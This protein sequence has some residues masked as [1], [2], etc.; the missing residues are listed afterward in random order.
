MIQFK[1]FPKMP[2]LSREVIVTEKIDGTNASIFIQNEVL[3]EGA[4]PVIVAR[5]G[6]FT[7]RVGSRTRW[8]TPSDDN[9]GF[10]NWVL[11]NSENLFGLG[12]G[13]H[14]GEWWGSGIQSGYGLQ[15]GEKRFSLFNT[16]RWSESRPSCTH[17][18]PVL[19]R[20]IFDTQRIQLVL[21]ELAKNG[22]WAAPGFMKPEG[23]VIY[24]VAG[25]IGF[26]KTIHKD[27]LPKSLAK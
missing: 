17:I 18:V 3:E 5:Q 27:E 6:G 14:F 25:N 10:A 24:H 21:D 9:H 11:K 13:H 1:E 12:E 22:S 26:K 19:W 2:R 20:G 7:M 8:I 16:E 15:K 23:I 4:D